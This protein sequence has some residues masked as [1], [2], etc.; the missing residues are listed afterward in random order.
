MSPVTGMDFVS[1]SYSKFHPGYRD[2]KTSSWICLVSVTGLECSYG[3]DFQ[4]GCRD[5]GFFR[6]LLLLR[7]K[8]WQGEISES[9]QPG[10]PGSY[11]EALTR[12]CLRLAFIFVD[13]VTLCCIRLIIESPYINSDC[14]HFC[15]RKLWLAAK[16]RMGYNGKWIYPK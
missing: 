13:W 6:P 3:K 2:E 15:L 5:L 9:D 11:E 8:E 14:I 12:V 1:C 16:T 4:L 7:R 10:W